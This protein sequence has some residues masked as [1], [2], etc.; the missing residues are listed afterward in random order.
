MHIKRLLLLIVSVFLYVSTGATSLENRKSAEEDLLASLIKYGGINHDQAELIWL[1]CRIELIHA[2]EAVEDPEFSVRVDKYKGN[3]ER[4]SNGRSSTKEETQKIVNILH[5]FVKQ[6]LL[7]CL[8]EKN[9][10]FLVSGEESVSKT[11]YSKC[12]DFLFVRSCAPK[13]RELFQSCG[14]IPAPSPIVASHSPKPSMPKVA[15]S[16]PHADPPVQPFNPRKLSD[17]ATVKNSK[18]N[19]S[20]SLKAQSEQS[21]SAPVAAAAVLVL[22][23]VALLSICCY[24]ICG[25]GSGKGQ[26]DERPLLS[27]S[28][29]ASS[30]KSFSLGSSLSDSK[31][32]IHSFHNSNDKMDCNLLM[33]PQ[34]LGSSRMEN[35]VGNG[36]TRVTPIEDSAP[37]KPPPGK[38][39]LPP[40]KPPPGR[41]VLPPPPGKTAPPASAPEPTPAPEPEPE[42]ES[43]TAPAATTTPTTTTTST[44]PPPP[45]PNAASSGP[46]APPP[47]LRP[48]S[49]GPAA[50]GPPPLPIPSGGKAGP[51]PPPPPGGAGRGGPPPPGPGPPRPP[52][53]GGGR[54]VGFRPPMA[55][56]GPSYEDDSNKAK[57]KPFF[58]DKV[59]ANPDNTMVWNQIRGGSFQFNEEMIETLFGAAPDKNKAGTKKEAAEE[60]PQYIQIIDQKKAQNLSILLKALNVTTT[61]VC[62]ALKEGNELPAELI[63]TLLRMAPTTEEELKLRLFSGELTQLGLAERFLKVLV[64][65][66]F[67]YK[68]LETLLFMCTLQEEAAMVKESF[69]TLE[70]ACGKLRKSRLFLKLLE[71]VLKTGNRMNSGTYRGGA[72]AFKLDTLLKLSDVKGKDGKTTLLH[73]VVSEIIRLEGLRSA[74]ASRELRSLSSIKSDDLSLELPQESDEQILSLGLEVVS[75]LGT[76]LEHVKRAALIDSDNLTG[77]VARLGHGLLNTKNFLNTDMKSVNEET[78]FRE[79]LESFMQSA[80]SQVMGLLEQEKQIMALVKSTGD[81]FHGNSGK[82]EGLRLFVIVRDFMLM[83]E[84]VCTEIRAQHKKNKAAKKE[85]PSGAPSEQPAKSSTQPVSKP[86]EPA[87]SSTQPLSKPSEPAQ[88]STQPVSKPSEPAQ[89]STQP[90]ST[91]SEPAPSTRPVSTPSSEEPAQSTQPGSTPSSSEES[92]QSTQ[93]VSTPSEEPVQSTQSVST[94]SE[95]PAQSTQPVSTPSKPPQPPPKRIP[96]PIP[97]PKRVDSSSSSDED[98]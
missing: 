25:G 20:Y 45:P 46:P 35:P 22:V 49:G 1:N 13:Q 28:S 23:A 42:P 89:S 69:L 98:E 50:P 15:K 27:L 10:M 32:G 36:S 94:P 33:E 55:P 97:R 56:F 61:E 40:L 2:K 68:R 5:P 84:K 85:N 37:L 57:L 12:L 64:E 82:D 44:S 59:L 18:T 70:A 9:L 24:M 90:V 65:I 86:S 51:L 92:I 74:R 72:Q 39:G 43:E 4:V 31:S 52:G 11:W 77:T 73:F 38:A 14:E 80:E 58:W 6:T 30:Q 62:D 54:L 34:T 26:N 93:P 91:P 41:T 29:A 60:K 83:L 7:G 78:G 48:S 66:P 3:R 67:A 71:A 96:I 53:P 81:Y 19:L 95:E 87:Q 88:S 79:T 21:S 16:S 47:P 76:E 75:D 17:T 63:H 8:R